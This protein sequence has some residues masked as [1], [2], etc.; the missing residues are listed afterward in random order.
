MDRRAGRSRGG[1]GPVYLLG[2]L[3]LEEDKISFGLSHV[4]G[5]PHETPM[6]ETYTDPHE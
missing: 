1:R 6:P 3:L 2:L 4:D 5:T